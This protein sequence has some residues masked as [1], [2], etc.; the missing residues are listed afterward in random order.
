[1]PMLTLHFETVPETLVSDMG[2]V[3]NLLMSMLT[4]HFEIV[5]DILVSDTRGV[6]IQ[7]GH[8]KMIDPPPGQQ[9]EAHVTFSS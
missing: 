7:P 9:P 8:G 4:L 1:M 5:P 6:K 3:N 2:V